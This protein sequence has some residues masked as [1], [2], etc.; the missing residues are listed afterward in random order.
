MAVTLTG[1]GGLFTRLGKLF[2][3]IEKIRAHQNDNPNGLKKELEDYFAEYAAGD[4]FMLSGLPNE[5][6]SIQSNAMNALG[7]FQRAAAQTIIEM[8]KADNPQ[9]DLTIETALRELIRQMV[10]ASAT[11]Q[12]NSSNSIAVA[13]DAGNTGNGFAA[14]AN[15]DID[16][17][18][19]PTGSI[20]YFEENIRDEDIL[21][22]CTADAQ[23][24]GTTGRESFSVRGEAAVS[25]GRHP[26]W[27]DTRAGSGISSTLRVSDPAEN[28]VNTVG[29]NLLTNSAFETFTVANTP[30]NWTIVTGIAGTDIFEEG[31]IIY[32]GAKCLALKGTAKIEQSL[33][34]AG[35]TPGKMQVGRKYF[36]YVRWRGDAG[37]VAGTV[38][39]SIKDGANNILNGGAATV[40]IAGSALPTGSFDAG[41]VFFNGPLVLPTGIKAVVE[42]ASI[43]ATKKVYIDDVLL[44]EAPKFQAS[45]PRIVITPGATPWKL[46]DKI[47]VSTTNNHSGKFQKFFDLMFGMYGRDLLLNHDSA[48]SISDGLIA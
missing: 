25:D 43:T 5:V 34:T 44:V 20:N 19:D 24:T 22:Q 18:L 30:N 39:I 2:F 8:I 16:L 12:R 40:T 13:Y 26:D 15:R 9:P 37:I 33:N 27:A 29:R 4:Q 38:T 42:C 11:V 41:S 17:L 48:P 7:S 3:V 14:A 10:A 35:Q 23:I 6:V 36:L 28:G 32:R 31:T 45:G 21:L 46:Q 47:T 1:A